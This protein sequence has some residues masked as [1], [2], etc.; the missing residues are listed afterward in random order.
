MYRR[1]A[2][3]RRSQPQL[4]A[5]RLDFAFRLGCGIR[6]AGGLCC[7]TAAGMGQ[8]L[9]VCCQL[10]FC[11]RE[12]ARSHSGRAWPR[13]VSNR[14]VEHERLFRRK[15]SYRR[16]RRGR[17][18]CLCRTPIRHCDGRAVS[19][20][21]VSAVERCSRNSTGRDRRHSGASGR[22][23]VP[24]HRRRGLRECECCAHGLGSG[25]PSVVRPA[26]RRGLSERASSHSAARTL[27]RGP[28]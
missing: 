9:R 22:L 14:H 27:T 19:R 2:S 7:S 15:R 8:R 11:R 1:V 26:A 12:R 16:S 3:S 18:E 17:R 6:S 23:P 20:E 13:R 5:P 21:D 28:A 25:G 24:W 4:N 10:R